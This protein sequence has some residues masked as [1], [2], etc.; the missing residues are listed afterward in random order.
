M[1]KKQVE[2]GT[3]DKQERMVRKGEGHVGSRVWWLHSCAAA[4]GHAGCLLESASTP[5][6]Q[7]SMITLVKFC[8]FEPKSLE[9]GCDQDIRV[10]RDFK[11]NFIN[12]NI[13]S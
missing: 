5:A 12:N 3:K 11:I 9:S 7:R 2:M 10:I 6:T 13:N 8:Q 4:D 1:E